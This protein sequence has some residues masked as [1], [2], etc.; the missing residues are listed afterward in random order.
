MNLT[1]FSGQRPVVA[2]LGLSSKCDEELTLG[3]LELL[4]LASTT[5]ATRETTE[6]DDLFVFHNVAEVSVS[7]GQFHAWQIR[8]IS[9]DIMLV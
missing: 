5:D 6:R 4:C 3:R 7:L 8:L 9:V 1:D 2:I